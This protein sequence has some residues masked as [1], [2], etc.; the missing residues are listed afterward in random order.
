MTV[1]S[2]ACAEFSA[3]LW[4]ALTVL[5]VPLVKCVFHFA[6]LSSVSLFQDSSI[7]RNECKIGTNIHKTNL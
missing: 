2:L 5:R 4:D 1:I 7:E 6:L 3:A